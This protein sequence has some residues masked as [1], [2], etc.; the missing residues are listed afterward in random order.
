MILKKDE[1]HSRIIV[2]QIESLLDFW[3]TAASSGT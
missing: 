2:F 1:K 3:L